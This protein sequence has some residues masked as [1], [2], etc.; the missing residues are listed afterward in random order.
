MK[1]KPR[2]KVARLKMWLKMPCDYKQIE[3]E[4][5]HWQRKAAK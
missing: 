5:A 2:K 4:I 3:R 1:L